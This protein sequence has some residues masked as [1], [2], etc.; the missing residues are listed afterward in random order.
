MNFNEHFKKW[1][2]VILPASVIL[3]VFLLGFVAARISNTDT[4]APHSEVEFEFRT[5]PQGI[6][7]EAREQIENE[8]RARHEE[9]EAAY[10]R[11]H[12]AQEKINTMVTENGFKEQE[13]EEAFI[14]L[15]KIEAEIRRPMQQ[16][17]IKTM[18]DM[19]RQSRRAIV[20]QRRE[21]RRNILKHPERV[22]GARW[23]FKME[24]GN[25]KLNMDGLRGLEGLGA[26]EGLKELENLNE[27][28]FEIIISSDPNTD[29][30]TETRV[31][32]I[33]KNNN[34]E[35]VELVKEKDSVVLDL[36]IVEEDEKEEAAPE[37]E[38]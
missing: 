31:F 22:D 3:N 7:R 4:Q 10:E 12:V 35:F 27:E 2:G 23:E 28:N 33:G 32:V 15:R 16:A 29:G 11:L 9:L 37:D 24:D 14:E 17:F 18:R 6:S 5:L 19:D 30:E 38:K 13:L 1:K 21:L 20:E 25:F 8:M 26:L 36:I 34:N